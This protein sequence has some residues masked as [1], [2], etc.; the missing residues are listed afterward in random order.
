MEG[1]L[2]NNIKLNIAI[3]EFGK[4]YNMKKNENKI[5]ISFKKIVAIFIVVCLLVIGG[6]Q[7]KN[8]IQSFA[9]RK[10]VYAVYSILEAIT[11]GYIENL[12]MEYIYSDGVGLKI[13]SFFMSENDINLILDFKLNDKTKLEG[14]KLE[15]A[16]I[17]YNENNE[18]YHVEKG[19]NTN[20]MKEFIKENDIKLVNNDIEP[21]FLT[22]QHTYITN[23][24]DNISVSALMSAKDYFPKAKKLY[25]KVVGIGYKNEK[26]NYKA[27]S[28]S[29]WNIEL[30]VPE[31][32]YSDKVVEYE[33]RENISNINLEKI[34]ISN[35]STTLIAIIDGINGGTN[36]KNSISIVDENGKEYNTNAIS[37]D[38]QNKNKITCQFPIKKNMATNKMYLKTIVN[39]NENI[40]ELVRK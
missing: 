33:L 19:T 37:F 35:T 36:S 32:F 28:N 4:G 38:G 13:N 25:I 11:D 22:G 27:L 5:I 17:L 14:K 21:H 20:I 18:V 29:E 8:I 6:V 2:L 10:P 1:Q 40:V 23:T 9:N 16:Y 30:D 34:I 31:K 7:A 15:Y 12:N 3:S 24:E 26:G 39:E